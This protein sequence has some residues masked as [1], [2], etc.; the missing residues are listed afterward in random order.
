MLTCKE[1][2]HLIS[3]AL[4]RPLSWRERLKLRAHLALCSGCRAFRRQLDFLRSA[5]QRFRNGAKED[6]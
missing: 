4:D 2:T 5:S 1:A 3:D 6:D